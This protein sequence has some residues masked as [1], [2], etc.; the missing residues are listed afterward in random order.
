[1]IKVDQS[2]QEGF[3]MTDDVIT[4]SLRVLSELLHKHYRQKS[5]LLIDEYD[6]PMDK[7]QN[8]GYYDQMLA[9]IRRLLGQALKSNNSLFCAVLVCPG[10]VFSLD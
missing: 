9:L 3:V 2:G 8:Y 4:D 1:M 5:I 10:R 6:V 7:A